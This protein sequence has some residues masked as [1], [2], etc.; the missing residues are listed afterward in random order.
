MVRRTKDGASA[1]TRRGFLA[2][3]AAG[4]IVLAGG[5]PALGGSTAV[6]DTP[7]ITPPNEVTVTPSDP[8]F[9]YLAAR[10]QNR[11]FST[12]PQEIYQV[13]TSDQVVDVVN[14]AV[15]GGRRITVRSGGHCTDGLVDIPQ[16]HAVIDVSRMK[17]VSW[18]TAY[19]AYSVGAGTMLGEAYQSLLLGYGVVIP[20]GTCPTVGIAGLTSGGG[21][22]SMC[23]QYGMCVDHLYGVE[24]VVVD[25]QGQAKTV[26]ATREA[27]DPDRPLWWGYTG[28]GGGNFG[29]A[30]RFLFRSPGSSGSDPTTALPR[31]PASTLTATVSWAWSALNQDAFVKLVR[32]HGAWHEQ[33]AADGGSYASMFSGFLLQQAV[34]G[35]IR[36]IVTLDGTRSDAADLANAYIAA[37][38][39]GVGVPFTAQLSTG[40]WL[41]SALSDPY[42]GATGA[43]PRTK[44]KGAYLRQSFTEAQAATVYTYLADT[45]QPAGGA[46]GIVLFS[47]GGKINTVASSA[48]ANPHRDSVLLMNL[49]AYWAD[50][51]QDTVRISWV[52]SLYADLFAT[53]GGVPAPNTGADGSYINYPDV[54]LAD[55]TVNTSGIPWS[56]LYFKDNYQRLQ[57]VKGSYDPGNFFRHPLSVQ[58]PS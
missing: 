29:V 28:A 2:G 50:A 49:G 7:R 33:H 53:T 30:T 25:A 46:A 38:N 41:N 6:A 13:F 35:Q 40:P 21:F 23:R 8:R 14:H 10:G 18:D 58:L 4:G 3:S 11:R 51:A 56:Q 22:G 32:N 17:S 20:G 37:I 31:P 15:Q 44:G 24:S 52:R 55:T 47:Y 27:S 16:S 1:L 9:G 48:T 57:Q 54:D 42:G 12:P 19:R 5:V 34:T 26:L 45:G 43:L 39:D 36:L